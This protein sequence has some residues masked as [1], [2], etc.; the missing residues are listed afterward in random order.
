[1]STLAS[2]L[3]V[4]FIEAFDFRKIKKSKKSLSLLGFVIAMLF[5]IS[6]LVGIYSLS[7]GMQLKQGNADLK[8]NVYI[9]SGF[10]TTMCCVMSITKV[11]YI[12]QSKDYDN[13]A[14]MPIKKSQIILSKLFSLYLSVILYSLVIMLPS[15]IVTFVMSVY[16]DLTDYTIL[17]F[18]ILSAFFIPA[19]PLSIGAI[20]CTLFTLITDKFRFGNILLIIAYMIYLGAVFYVSFSF[21]SV[22]VDENGV[23]DV[24]KM[25]SMAKGMIWINPTNWFLTRDSLVILWVL[26]YVAINIL[27]L[28]FVSL[29]ISLFFEK[30]HFLTIAKKTSKK[31]EKKYLDVKNS[32]STFF[33]LELKKFFGNKLYFINGSLSGIMV[34][35]MG[36]FMSYQFRNDSYEMLPLVLFTVML[37]VLAIQTPACV[38]I[39][40]EGKNFYVLKTMPIDYR[41][42]VFA[43]VLLSGLVTAAF[44]VVGAAISCI[45][46]KPSIIVI[47]CIIV[48]IILHSFLVSIVDMIISLKNP[49]LDWQDEKEA[50][51]QSTNVLISLLLGTGLSVLIIIVGAIAAVFSINLGFILMDVLL[52]MFTIGFGYILSIN[53]NKDV[54]IIE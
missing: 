49:K 54:E 1:M 42:Y 11:N 7:F 21:N 34:I 5:F 51:K 45:L 39:N 15:T 33:R 25:V 18:G 4:Q 40:L 23:K 10:A 50:I 6:F 9:F 52:L 2:L 35:F 20:I 38:S 46:I 12:F 36:I 14:A 29:F 30:I 53:A 32:F 27:L 37:C 31:Y 41:K 19:L 26:V 24:S 16:Y 13:L 28:V 43:K 44:S 22:E 48:G 3:K 8:Y 47:V 17:S